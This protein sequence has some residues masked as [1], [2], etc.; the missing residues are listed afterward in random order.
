MAIKKQYLKSKP[1]CKV[2]FSLEAEDAEKVALVGCFNEWDSKDVPLKKLKNGTFKATVD[3]PKDQSYEF[4]Y[5][6]DGE[7]VN[8]TAADAYAWND[9]A[10]TENGVIT[11]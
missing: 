11:V 9:Y 7:Y 6:V 1:I 8:D 5:I 2:T 3:L 10:G 4:R